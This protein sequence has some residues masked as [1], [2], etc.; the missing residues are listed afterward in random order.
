[1]NL[2]FSFYFAV[3]LRRIHYFILITVVV[4]AAAIAAAFLR[5]TSATLGI[6][7]TSGRVGRT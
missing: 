1:M 3:F 2:D 6:R 5:R 7:V 4:S